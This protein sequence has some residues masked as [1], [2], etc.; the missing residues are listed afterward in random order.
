MALHGGEMGLGQLAGAEAP[1]GQAGEGL[2]HGQIGERG[3]HSTTLGTAKKPSAG[4]GALASSR[5][6]ILPSVTSSAALRQLAGDDARHR[7]DAGRIDLAQLLD[8]GEDLAEIAHQGVGF[9]IADADA[10]ER[11]DMPDGGTIQRHGA[12][13]FG[14]RDYGE[15]AR[16]LAKRPPPATRAAGPGLSSSQAQLIMPCQ[17]AVTPKARMR[18]PEPRAIQRRTGWSILW[19][20]TPIPK[21]RQSHQAAEPPKTPS[22]KVAAAA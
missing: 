17:A 16:N 18:A 21:L 7:L 20:M 2:D 10:G 8:P 22:T 9:L 15:M 13:S 5:S 4:S 6:R 14:G 11:G 1:L 19:R 12:W 3:H